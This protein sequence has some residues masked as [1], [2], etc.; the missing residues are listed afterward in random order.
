[1][2]RLLS[3]TEIESIPA[4]VN[5]NSENGIALTSIREPPA[6]RVAS[7]E[8]NRHDVAS[9]ENIAEQE[10]RS[11]KKGSAIMVA[12]QMSLI[13][14]ICSVTNGLITISIPHMADE[15]GLDQSLL[16]WLDHR[17]SLKMHADLV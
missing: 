5:N 11:F 16:Y 9:T 4:V 10:T 6:S 8:S 14:F 13:Y 1:M 17:L 2:S 7:R 3:T 12:L 15:L